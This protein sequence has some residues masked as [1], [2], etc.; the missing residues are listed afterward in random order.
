MKIAVPVIGKRLDHSEDLCALVRQSRVENAEITEKQIG[1]VF[2]TEGDF[3]ETAFDQV[4]FENCR[5]AGCCF[6]KCSFVDVIFRGCDLSNCDFR[7]GYFNRCEFRS[8]KG[9]GANFIESGFWNTLFFECGM[10]YSNLSASKLEKL[11]IVKSD[12]SE[13][14]LTSVT[15]KNLQLENAEFRK[16]NFFKTSLKEI[17]FTSCGLEGIGVSQDGNELRGA[18]VNSLQAAELAKLLGLVVK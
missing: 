11:R 1:N 15:Q 2:L 17:D 8:V 10:R 3:R 4:V 14:F 18:I 12:F 6:A 5:L 9:I 13:S 16:T 7:N